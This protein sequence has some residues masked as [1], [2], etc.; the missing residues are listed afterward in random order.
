MFD[1]ELHCHDSKMIGKVLL[2]DVIHD[3]GNK[4]IPSALADLALIL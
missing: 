3:V 2:I 1:I 4:L